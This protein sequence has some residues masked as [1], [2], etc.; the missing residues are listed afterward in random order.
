MGAAR[1]SGKKR[2]DILT[3]LFNSHLSL[4]SHHRGGPGVSPYVALGGGA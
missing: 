2:E 3:H 4:I 1:V